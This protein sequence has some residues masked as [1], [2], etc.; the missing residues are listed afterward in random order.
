MYSSWKER[1]QS[2]SYKGL[3]R[4]LLAVLGDDSSI[5][6][7]ER[8][9]YTKTSSSLQVASGNNMP[10][11]I[12]LPANSNVPLNS[13]QATSVADLSTFRI[14]TN[15]SNSIR[16]VISET[17]HFDIMG[18][19]IPAGAMHLTLQEQTFNR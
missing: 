3:R 2:I 14:Q 19:S 4:P 5:A 11:S 10:S 12:Q 15:F 6:G 18:Y 1:A 8:T 16:V 9:A 17:K 7:S 13:N